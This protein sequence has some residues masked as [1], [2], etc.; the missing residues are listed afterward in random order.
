[1]KA[2]LDS[3]LTIILVVCAVSTTGVVVYRQFGP[4]VHQ[5]QRMP[6]KPRFLEDWKSQLNS[7][8]QLGPRDAPVQLV[9]FADFECPFCR[10][11]HKE[12]RRLRDHYPTQVA[13]TFVYFP[14]PGHRFAIPAARGA[15]CARE[16]GRFE[17]MYDQLFNDQDS[18]GLKTWGDY[19]SEAGVSNLPTFE[20]CLKRDDPRGLIGEGKRLAT[21]LDVKGTPTLIINGWMLGRP[22][23]EQELN[24][25]VL[26]VLAG[27]QA[28]DGKS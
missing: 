22:P 23:N 4:S 13:L 10:E 3:F 1:M 8:V 2:K 6:E 5:V 15:E 28:V 9:E 18:F 21:K 25:M 24:Q 16:Q 19:A 12:L 27:K 20:A 7:G 17:A 11:L 14:L 26:R